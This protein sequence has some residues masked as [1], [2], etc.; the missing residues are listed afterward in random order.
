[1]TIFYKLENKL[2]V[3]ITNDCPCDCTFCIRNSYDGVGDATSL[4]LPHPPTL[5]EIFT[6][7]DRQDL[8]DVDEIVFCGYG[9]PLARGKEIAVITAYLRSKTSLPFRLNTNGLAV[10]LFSCFDF[11]S[12]AAFETV[13]V[14]LNAD[15]A[16]EYVRLV[17]PVFGKESYQAVLDFIKKARQH[18]TVIATVVDVLAPERIENC[19]EL[20]TAL[21]VLFRVRHLQ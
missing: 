5:H 1:M 4:W 13:S 21:G 10:L 19:R 15:D 16:D 14:S 18:T 20:T 7:F 17:Q 12:L 2:Y 3:N 8:S 9:E 6:A 11:D